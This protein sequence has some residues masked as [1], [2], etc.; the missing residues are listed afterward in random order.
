MR[1]H[2]CT[3]RFCELE[4]NRPGLRASMLLMQDTRPIASA[5]SRRSSQA[6]SI[7]SQSIYEVTVPTLLTASITSAVVLDKG[8]GTRRAGEDRACGAAEHAAVPEHVPADAQVQIASDTAKG[9]VARL[10]AVEPPKF[11]DNESGFAELQARVEKTQVFCAASSRS[12]LEAF[13]ESPRGAQVP[14]P[15]AELQE[16]LGLSADASCCRTSTFTVR[17][18]TPFCVMAAYRSARQTSSARLATAERD[19]TAVPPGGAPPP[20]ACR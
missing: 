1:S 6:R 3:G 17:P 16:R 8:R 15:H 11:E 9:A 2:V 5:A 10:A 12:Q 20:G 19:R 18:R 4:D 14:E 13:G 7:M